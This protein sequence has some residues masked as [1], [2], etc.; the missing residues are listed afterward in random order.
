MVGKKVR[1]LNLGCSKNQVDSESILGE[2][3]RAGFTLAKEGD[4]SQ[5][6]IINTCG[7]IE[8][9]KEESIQEILDAAGAKGEGEKLVVAGCLSQRYM[10]DLKKDIPEVDLYVGTYKPGEII[11]RLGLS[12]TLPSD[13]QVGAAP[14]TL[15]G[16]ES[17]HAFLKIAEGCN[18]VCGFCAIPGMRGKQKSR[19]IADIV[20]EAQDLQSWGIKE[21]SLIAQD[22]TYFGREKNGTETLEALLKALLKETDI[23]WFRMMYAYPAFV[24]DGLIDVMAT[25]R[26]VCKYL[27]MPMQHA[28]DRMLN[29]MRRNYTAAQLKDI[30]RRLRGAVPGIALRST[31]LV[32]YPGETEADMEEL[33]ALVEEVRF[34]HLGCFT[35][36]DEDG[37]HAFDLKPKVKPDVMEARMDRVM[38]LQRQIA[39]EDNLKRVGETI[40]V[41]IDGVAE[42]EDYHF[43]GRTE[44]DAPEVDN[45][46][47]IFANAD[48]KTLGADPGT[49]RKALV[50]DAREY[51]LEANLLP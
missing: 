10:E 38:S 40:E 51:D 44:G 20:K 7:F 11:E 9:A 28:S 50:T 47:L 33:L 13:C 2:F 17:H 4:S 21:V 3:G 49:F 14:R 22:L 26:R 48:G 12:S 32:G 6:T 43:T 23:A 35:Y 5:L 37:T 8:A 16:E 29:A 42:G 27:D 19:K 18:R 31:A 45:R 1:L 46:V 15:M 39:L 30:L 24:T 25:E 36:S 34:R 41:V